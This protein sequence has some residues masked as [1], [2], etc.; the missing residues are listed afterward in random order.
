MLRS[1]KH[2]RLCVIH[3]R[4]EHELLAADQAARRLVS[5]SGDF[6]TAS[7]INHVLGE[8]FRLVAENRI[9]HRD[10]VSLAY[11]AQ[12]LLQS[13]PHVRNEI[14]H[15]LGYRVW[16]AT[17]QRALTPGASQTEEDS[18]SE[19]ASGNEPSADSEDDS[20]GDAPDNS[21]N[22]N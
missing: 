5:L 3:A 7:D 18:E 22:A 12:L 21:E 6:K 17:V 16:D 13:L 19:A 9:P 15:A 10:A 11:I 20:D 8:L 2:P 14:N 1:K 4:S